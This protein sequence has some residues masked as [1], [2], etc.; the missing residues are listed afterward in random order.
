MYIARNPHSYDLYHLIRENYRQVFFNKEILGTHLPFHLILRAEISP[1]V[2][3]GFTALYVRKISLLLLAAK[4]A[5][6]VQVARVEEC[7]I[8]PNI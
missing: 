2:W 5:R 4:G 3:Q 7:R 1:L 6:F 8:P